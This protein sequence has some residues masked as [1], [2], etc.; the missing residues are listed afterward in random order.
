MADPLG[1]LRKRRA[2][3]RKDPPAVVMGLGNP[4]EKYTRTR[5]NL[6]FRCVDLVAERAGIRFNDKRK[7][8]LEGQGSLGETEMVLAKPRTFMNLSGVA[9]RYLADRFRAK[10]E[11]ILVVID[12]L[13]LPLGSIRLRKGGGSGGHNGL[14]SISDEL[15]SQD[16]PRLRIGIGRPQ[17]DA[18]QHVLAGFSEDEERV[19]E[20]AMSRAADAVEAWAEHGIDHA[21]NLFN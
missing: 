12:D 17:R 20:E 1:W 19:I 18:I 8:A 3:P 15:G 11:R 16:Y 13:D 6:G 7:H 5:H 14:N 9:A 4:G 21:M 2:G 10:P